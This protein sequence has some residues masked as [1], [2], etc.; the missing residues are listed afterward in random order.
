L[1]YTK[2]FR[3]FSTI[4]SDQIS[5]D[6]KLEVKFKLDNQMRSEINKLVKVIWVKDKMIG[7]K[8]SGPKTFNSELGFY[9]RT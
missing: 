2:T 8:F 4:G 3:Q 9:L 5:I 6:D 7:A 1:S